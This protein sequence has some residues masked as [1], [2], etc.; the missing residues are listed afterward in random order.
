M[1]QLSRDELGALA[2]IYFA[3]EG[4]Y[5]YIKE[6]PFLGSLQCNTTSLVAGQWT[7][8]VITYTVGS[9]GL[10]DGAWIKG[11][12]KFYSVCLASSSSNH[13]TTIAE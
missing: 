3:P 13:H 5:R 12:F 7:E 2:G 11:T 9:S 8:V 10:A 4:L 1:K 6:L